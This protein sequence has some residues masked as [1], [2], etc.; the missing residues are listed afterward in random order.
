MSNN[1]EMKDEYDLPSRGG[2][3]GK[4]YERYTQQMSIK[5][6]FPGSPFVASI[7]SS[8]PSIGTITKTEPYPFKITSPLASVHAS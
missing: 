6:V 4:Y 5:L 1:E 7:T 3:R 2:V 8:A